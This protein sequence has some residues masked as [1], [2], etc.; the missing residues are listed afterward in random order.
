MEGRGLA[1]PWP[2]PSTEPGA[3]IFRGGDLSATSAASAAWAAASSCARPPGKTS[4]FLA[5]DCDD[6]RRLTPP[7]PPDLALLPELGLADTLTAAPLGST[8]TPVSQ[9]RRSLGRGVGA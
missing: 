1:Y 8:T 6:R 7:R 4:I 9:L 3:A 2:A 5:A